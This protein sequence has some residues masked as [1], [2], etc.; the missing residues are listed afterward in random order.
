MHKTV[1]K[2][3]VGPLLLWLAACDTPNTRFSPIAFGDV[4]GIAAGGNLRLVTERLRQISN[5][6]G[7]SRL[8]MCSEPSPDYVVAFGRSADLAV[9]VNGSGGVGGD[10]SAKFESS[11][12]AQLGA[13]RTAGVLA[14]RD[15]LYAACQAYANGVIGQD[16]YSI[17]LSQY[18]LLIAAVAS[19]STNNQ[20]PTSSAFA[21]IL[22]ACLSDSDSTRLTGPYTRRNPLLQGRACRDAVTRAASGKIS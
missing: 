13:G 15:G 20:G 22:V 12:L 1:F 6:D 16:A 7:A 14:L 4:N 2:L 8:V 9:K 11:E 18:G 10:G 5:E 21:A 19:G 17:I 3:S